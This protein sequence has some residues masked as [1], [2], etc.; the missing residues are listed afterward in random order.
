MFNI[1]RLGIPPLGLRKGQLKWK[2][3][4]WTFLKWQYQRYRRTHSSDSHTEGRVKGID[5]ERGKWRDN[6][7]TDA[8]GQGKMYRK[9]RDPGTAR[10]V[11]AKIDMGL[12]GFDEWTLWKEWKPR[13]YA[14][15]FFSFFFF[16]LDR[17]NMCI[18]QNSYTL[19]MQVLWLC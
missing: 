10:W 19:G 11:Y 7:R 4:R 16:K 14:F 2:G 18:W 13:K 17:V 5:Y 1:F 8:S 9:L 15:F 6:R 12:Q 3:K